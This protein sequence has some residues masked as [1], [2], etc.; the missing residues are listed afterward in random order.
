MPTLRQRLPVAV[1]PQPLL[2]LP[3][4]DRA[5]ESAAKSRRRPRPPGEHG[6]KTRRRAREELVGSP[7]APRKNRDGARRGGVQI[8][9]PTAV[10]PHSEQPAQGGIRRA[11][12]LHGDGDALQGVRAARLLDAGPDPSKTPRAV[13]GEGSP[14]PPRVMSTPATWEVSTRMCSISSG[15]MPD[16]LGDDVTP[17]QGLHVTAE[18]AEKRFRLVPLGVSDDDGLP[19]PQ[20]QAARG[21]L[22]GHPAREAQGVHHGLL[23]GGVGPHAASA[24]GGDPAWCRGWR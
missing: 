13:S 5:T 14:E 12:A 21:G 18:G 10:P 20:I 9:E 1:P 4:D 7:F 17:A 3:R 24:Q 6:A 19:A 22:V 23:L 2:A 16:V 15:E 8:R 11:R